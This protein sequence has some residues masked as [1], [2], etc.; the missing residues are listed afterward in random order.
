MLSAYRAMDMPSPTPYEGWEGSSI[1]ITARSMLTCPLHQANIPLVLPRA[2]DQ[3]L[4]VGFLS[5]ICIIYVMGMHCRSIV[6]DIMR[7]GRISEGSVTDMGLFLA[8]FSGDRP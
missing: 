6:R 3:I 5:R 4:R 8:L 7:H 1:M 2:C